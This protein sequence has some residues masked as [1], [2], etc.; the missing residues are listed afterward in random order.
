MRVEYRGTQYMTYQSNTMRSLLFGQA[1]YLKSPDY[2]HIDAD[3]TGLQFSG[4]STSVTSFTIGMY[5]F[6]PKT[7][8]IVWSEAI[9]HSYND[10]VEEAAYFRL[11]PHFYKTVS[12]MVYTNPNPTFIYGTHVPIP[13][14]KQS[15]WIHITYTYEVSTG[16]VST[17]L[18]GQYDAQEIWNLWNAQGSNGAY[19]ND[20]KI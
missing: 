19:A 4:S 14:S 10:P 16:A 20:F 13:A 1:L 6:A 18:D 7:E 17:Y 12:Q 8:N 15:G 2:V 3:G 5:I 11:M 9:M